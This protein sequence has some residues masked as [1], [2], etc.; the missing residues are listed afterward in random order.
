MGACTGCGLD[1]CNTAPRES[2]DCMTSLQTI[3][4][5]DQRI[6]PNPACAP[7]PPLA[8]FQLS[9]L[10]RLQLCSD[11][12]SLAAPTPEAQ[13]LLAFL[14]VHEQPVSRAFTAAAL[15]PDTSEQHSLASLRTALS[16]MD[17]SA[18]EAIAITGADLSLAGDVVVDWRDARALAHRILDPVEAPPAADLNQQ[19]VQALSGD[20]LPDWYEDWAI[21]ESERWRQ[22]RLHALDAL[23]MHLSAAGR[24]DSAVAAAL[25]AVQ[26]EPLR[27]SG[28][29]ALIRVHLAE[30]NQSEA[31]RV[32]N[33]Y[34]A[35]LLS[36]LGIEPT[37][38]LQALP[39]VPTRTR[40]D[41]RGASADARDQHWG[42]AHA[43]L[44]HVNDGTI[45]TR[46]L[47]RR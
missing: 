45:V 6:E 40:T 34:R 23:A 47:H 1:H 27:E 37:P 18:R 15:W 7:T 12:Q 19:A 13:R 28:Y 14:A 21:A 29:A 5:R 17:R 31:I 25:A 35:L 20:M 22:L 30:G 24:F 42:S 33:Q 44:P 16:R 36:E 9:I 41:A 4:E 39:F 11:A 2:C 32:L 3:G 10:G 8:R 26:S 38:T 43:R 46:A